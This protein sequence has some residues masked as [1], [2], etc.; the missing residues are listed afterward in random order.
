MVGKVA[1]ASTV[2][3]IIGEKALQNSSFQGGR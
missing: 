2:V 3:T 1:T